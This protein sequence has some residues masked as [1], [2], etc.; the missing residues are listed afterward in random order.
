MNPS[1]DEILV[2]GCTLFQPIPPR[3]LGGETL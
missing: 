3:R 2:D 1:P